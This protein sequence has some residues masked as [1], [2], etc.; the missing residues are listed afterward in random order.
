MTKDSYWLRSGIYTMLIRASAML[1]GLGGFYFLAR[2]LPKADFG[3]WALF[4]MVT[5][6][7]EVA[8]N[9]LIQNAFV[10]F[11]LSN[12]PADRPKIT[13]A[14]LTINVLLSLVSVVVLLAVAPLLSILWDAPELSFMLYFYAITTLILIPFS[15]SE[16]IHQANFDFRG[17]FWGHFTRMGTLFSFIA[18]MYLTAQAFSLYQLV[19]VHCIAA[20]LGAGVLTSFAKPY[21]KLTRVIDWSWVK[22]LFN[23]GKYV[24]GTGVSSMILN[25]IDSWMLGSLIGK[26]AVATYST[27]LKITNLVEVPTNAIAAM[28]FPQSAKR[29]ETEGKSAAKHLYEKSVGTLLAMIIPGIIFVLLIPG[30]LISLVAGDK[31]LDAVPI[32]QITMIY[33]L[34]MPFGR[35]FGII[36]DSIGKP[37]VNF[38]FILFSASL[39]VGLNYFF[40]HA[41]GMQIIGAAYGTLTT[42]VVTFIG[43]QI[44]LKRELDVRTL[45]TF[46]YAV[47]FY[48]EMYKMG[49]RLWN[50]RK[51]K[52]GVEGVID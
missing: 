36:L 16:F 19:I 18:F 43:T 46:V 15:Q 52:P 3:A 31:Y 6:L 47:K 5:S 33:G 20:L 44:L 38:Y 26:A 29:I 1:F 14:S 41:T 32:L 22:R 34:F 51:G 27:A 42:Y 24:F 48:P 30:P 9:A 25:S 37:K 12:E 17:V 2:A 50:K 49:K 21:Y 7:I 35:Q 28:V 45:N 11:Y 10:K 4:L 8:R 23:Y 13:T 40:I 39:N